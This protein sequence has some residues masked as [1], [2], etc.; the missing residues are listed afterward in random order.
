MYTQTS[1]F[2]Y[3]KSTNIKAIFCGK[4]PENNDFIVE[5]EKLY[6]FPQE[7]YILQRTLDKKLF[8]V[9]LLDPPEIQK[10]YIEILDES[11]KEDIEEDLQNVD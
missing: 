7:G 11:Q 4:L 1:Y 6:L 8:S 5:Q 10:N 9:V 2:G 3:F